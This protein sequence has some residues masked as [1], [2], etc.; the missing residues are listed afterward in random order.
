MRHN[1]LQARLCFGKHDWLTKTQSRELAETHAK[2]WL[3]EKFTLPE[4]MNLAKKPELNLPKLLLKTLKPISETWPCQ[5]KRKPWKTSFAK[6]NRLLAK[7]FPENFE[8]DFWSLSQ[9]DTKLLNEKTEPILEEQKLGKLLPLKMPDLIEAENL[10]KTQTLIC[11]TQNA[12]LEHNS[13][14]KN[15]PKDLTQVLTNGLRYLR[16]GGDGE[17]VQPE[18]W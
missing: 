15:W 17:A 9:F 13:I 8:A 4:K 12:N 18:K 10:L 5:T 6:W 3:C 11:K 7:T 2:N 16:W 14:L 1:F